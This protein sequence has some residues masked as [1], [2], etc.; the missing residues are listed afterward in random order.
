MRIALLALF[1]PLLGCTGKGDTA[2][3]DSSTDSVGDDTSGDSNPVVIPPPCAGESWGDIDTTLVA[4]GLHVSAN[5]DSGGD[6]SEEHPFQT[7]DEAV[8][9]SRVEGAPKAILIWP[10]TYTSFLD[11]A[12][13]LGDDG[14]QVQGCSADEVTIEAIGATSPIIKVSEV[15]GLDVRGLTLSGGKRGLWVWQGAK[16]TI[17]DVHAVGNAF[18]G[19][20]ID[21]VTTEATMSSIT[22]T[23]PTLSGGIGGFGIMVQSSQVSMDGVE[24]T[25]AT[26]NG[27]LVTGGTAVAL[28]TAVTVTGTSPDSDGAFGR[29]VTIQERASA[30]ISSAVLADNFDAGIFGL[31]PTSL[32]LADV[33]VTSTQAAHIP[34]SEDTSGD[35]VVITDDP[36]HEPYSEVYFEAS[37]DNVTIDGSSRTGMLLSGNGLGVT[38]S[39]ITITGF[40]ADDPGAGSPVVQSD[41]SVTSSDAFVT[42]DAPLL[43]STDPI[44]AD[45]FAP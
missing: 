19:I 9:A 14:L 31:G 3:D 21:G 22:V 10:G 34:G 39:G 29:G 35:G 32:A 11:L 38:L 5:A 40:T 4:T 28:M 42:L 16:V 37:A 24:V 20:V 25:G 6:G 30:D 17:T 41:A 15:S 44:I 2:V 7:I 33:S 8:T 1:V 13:S 36:S 27:I 23:D 12:T 18:L 43:F 26:E 45:D